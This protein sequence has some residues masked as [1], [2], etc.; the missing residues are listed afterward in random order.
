MT[1]SKICRDITNTALLTRQK[2]KN[3]RVV[4]D[5]RVIGIELSRIHMD[6]HI[7]CQLIFINVRLLI[8]YIANSFIHA[9]YYSCLFVEM[10]TLSSM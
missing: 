2:A 9:H 10:C 4:F 3:Y 7:C 5:K 1:D 8:M 6:I